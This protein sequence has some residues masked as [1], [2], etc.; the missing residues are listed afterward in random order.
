MAGCAEARERGRRLS[1]RFGRHYLTAWGMGRTGCR[2]PRCFE[3]H[4]LDAERLEVARGSRELDE[5]C[6]D[7][8]A[9]DGVPF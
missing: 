7:E 8:G 3:C 1:G 5:D 9:G 6:D 2:W 4:E